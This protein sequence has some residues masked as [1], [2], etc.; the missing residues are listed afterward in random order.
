MYPARRLTT[1]VSLSLSRSSSPPRS[2]ELEIELNN[3]C[4]LRLK[5]IIDPSLLQSRHHGGYEAT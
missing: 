5:G 4:M 3:S 2:A 1:A